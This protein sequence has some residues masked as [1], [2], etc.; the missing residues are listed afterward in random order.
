LLALLDLTL[1][2]HPAVQHG[3]GF[4]GQRGLLLEFEGLGFEFGGFLKSPLLVGVLHFLE[5]AIR[6]TIGENQPW[7]P[8][9]TAW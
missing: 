8:Q 1:V 2:A 9:T 7:K 5:R 4:G 3:A 6:E